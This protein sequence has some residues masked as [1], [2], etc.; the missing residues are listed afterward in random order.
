M[1]RRSQAAIRKLKDD[2]G[3]YLW[4]PAAMAGGTASLMNFPIAESE[5]MP[6]IGCRRIRRSPSATSAAAI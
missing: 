3:N 2:D 1:N 6:D 5:D 4:Q